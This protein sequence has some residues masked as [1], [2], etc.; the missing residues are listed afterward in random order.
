MRASY[1]NGLA[2]FYS[3]LTGFITRRAKR[4]RPLQVNGQVVTEAGARAR[5]AIGHPF[6]SQLGD[7]FAEDAGRFATLLRSCTLTERGCPLSSKNTV[8]VPSA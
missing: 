7:D 2:Q 1:S 4:I 3:D 5:E 6:F 8:R